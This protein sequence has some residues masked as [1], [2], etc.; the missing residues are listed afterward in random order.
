[1]KFIDSY[2]GIY[3]RRIFLY[4]SFFYVF[5]NRLEPGDQEIKIATLTQLPRK[6]NEKEVLSKI[7][8]LPASLP[9][10]SFVPLSFPLLL[11][12]YIRNPIHFNKYLLSAS[13][14]LG[15]NDLH[16]ESLTLIFH[17]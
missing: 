15:S 9:I 14:V 1:M 17:F 2:L 4:F 12:I 16:A 5:D 6:M 13:L 3:S 11:Q 10:P 8:S 7:L